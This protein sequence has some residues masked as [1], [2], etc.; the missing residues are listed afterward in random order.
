MLALVDFDGVVVRNAR[1]SSHVVRR[2]EG[3]LKKRMGPAATDVE[4]RR[5]NQELYGGFGHSFLGMKK[6]G[7]VE[8]R[9][10]GEFQDYLYSDIDPEEVHITLKEKLDW[11][12]FCQAMEARNIRVCIFSNASLRW[13]QHFINL[14][15][16]GGVGYLGPGSCDEWLKPQ[17]EVYDC[18]DRLYKGRHFLYYED[19]LVNLAPRLDHPDWTCVWVAEGCRQ[20]VVG[21]LC[22]VENLGDDGVLGCNRN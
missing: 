9:H 3:F 17:V 13:I 2:V 14:E 21:N 11:Q 22:R 18:I 5:L 20:G 19:K 6:M 10:F 16:F 1:A 7:L 12:R 15:E 4:V 8:A